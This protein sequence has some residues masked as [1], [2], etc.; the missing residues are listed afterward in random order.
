MQGDQH[1]EKI[2][3]YLFQDSFQVLPLLQHLLIC[4]LPYL[5][6]NQGSIL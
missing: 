5:M 3:D 2:N 1:V 4:H 6:I